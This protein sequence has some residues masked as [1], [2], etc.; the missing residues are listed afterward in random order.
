[1]DLGNLQGSL[2]HT[3]RTEILDHSLDAY[4]FKI[5]NKKGLKNNHHTVISGDIS[6]TIGWDYKQCPG[7]QVESQ[8]LPSCRLTPTPWTRWVRWEGSVGSSSRMTAAAPTVWAAPLTTAVSGN[9]WFHEGFL[10]CCSPSIKQ[11]EQ[12]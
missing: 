3:L 2:D 4:G 8:G 11:F 10:L 12:F 7:Q 5:K 9:S 6:P 1:M